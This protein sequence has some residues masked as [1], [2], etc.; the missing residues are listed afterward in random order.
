MGQVK[1]IKLIILAA[2]ILVALITAV[3]F[4][5][6]KRGNKEI[7][8]NQLKTFSESFAK[9]YATYNYGDTSSYNKKIQDYISNE[10]K[11]DF[12]SK[13]L[14]PDDSEVR[15]EDKNNYS[16]YVSSEINILSEDENKGTVAISYTALKT[17]APFRLQ[18]FEDKKAITI[19]VK[20]EGKK[21]KITSFQFSTT[22]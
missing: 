18:E 14:L 9:D 5:L 22:D 4:F 12:S 15:P 21:I 1:K 7:L 16:N 6:S 19:T 2:V 10:Y 20:K 8:Q 17:D 3:S 11:D 13:Y